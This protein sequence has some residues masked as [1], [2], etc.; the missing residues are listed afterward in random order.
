L[1]KMEI[2]E[3]LSSVENNVIQGDYDNN[4][5]LLLCEKIQKLLRNE[6][7][8]YTIGEK[9]SNKVK[10]DLIHT[11]I[12]VSPK[13]D[14]E[15]EL[16]Y[17]VECEDENGE[18]Y[19]DI[20]KESYLEEETRKYVPN[21]RPI[22]SELRNDF[23]DDNGIIFIDAWL[24]NDGDEEGKVIAKIYKNEQDEV[25]VEYLDKRAKVDFY[26]QEIIQE[27]MKK[28]KKEMR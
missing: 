18:I 23:R 7:S 22:W 20:L 4:E 1:L 15:A 25:N 10:I 6:L 21:N 26:A 2:K 13:K 28:L 9:F 17:F 8:K 27:S 3:L 5:I 12:A 11:I 19:Y 24:T 16:S 14:Y